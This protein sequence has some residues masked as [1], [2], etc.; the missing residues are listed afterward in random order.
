MTERQSERSER[1]DGQGSPSEGSYTKNKKPTVT[2]DHEQEK[3]HLFKMSF[4]IPRIHSHG[5]HH[6]S[7]LALFHDAR[8]IGYRGA[9]FSICKLC[10]D[11]LFNVVRKKGATNAAEAVSYA[12]KKKAKH[13]RRILNCFP[14]EEAQDL[15]IQLLGNGPPNRSDR[16]GGNGAKRI[17]M[18]LTM[19]CGHTSIK[20][21][22]IVQPFW[23]KRE[24]LGPILSTGGPADYGAEP[25]L[26]MSPEIQHF[27]IGTSII[28]IAENESWYDSWC[29][30]H[31]DDEPDGSDT[32][33]GCAESDSW[34]VPH[35]ADEPDCSTES[36]DSR[37][38]TGQGTGRE[39][40]RS[41]SDFQAGGQLENEFIH[42]QR[43]ENMETDI[44]NLICWLRGQSQKPF[45]QILD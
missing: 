25:I 1:R 38:F 32:S 30:P 2:L 3:K 41:V 29:V 5:Q 9:C 21:S 36:Q 31:F 42:L 43:T 14:S 24:Y 8:R 6:S 35:F 7:V 28:D 10:N 22:Y 44:L 34:W 18:A 4:G 17:K 33:I 19:I 16:R 45:A 39:L 23:A 26:D 15:L 11:A 37:R 27:S 40:E 20:L 12:S 13:I